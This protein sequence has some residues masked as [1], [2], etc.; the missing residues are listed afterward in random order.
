MFVDN[1]KFLIEIDRMFKQKLLSISVRNLQHVSRHKVYKFHYVVKTLYKNLWNALLNV[2][3][4]CEIIVDNI[5]FLIESII[6]V[7]SYL[8]MSEKWLS[9]DLQHVSRDK[10]TNFSMILKHS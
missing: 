5:E 8:K 6:S 9:I 4:N 10:V 7:S 1:I 2:E 3:K